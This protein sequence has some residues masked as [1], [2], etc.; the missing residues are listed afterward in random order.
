MKFKTRFINTILN[1]SSYKY[2]YFK[3][4]STLSYSNFKNN[5]LYEKFNHT[6]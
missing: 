1:F 5:V 3:M 6:K 4:Y 2:Y